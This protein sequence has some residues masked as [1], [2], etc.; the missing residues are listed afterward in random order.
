MNIQ[1]PTGKTVHV[2]IVEFLSLEDKEVEI[3]YQE[4]IADDS[5]DFME[6]PF[7]PIKPQKDIRIDTEEEPDEFSI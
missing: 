1:L 5:G 2:S 4:L 7:S 6:N 3:F